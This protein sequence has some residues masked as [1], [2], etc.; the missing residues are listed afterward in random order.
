MLRLFDI[1]AEH[2]VGA[3][4]AIRYATVRRQ[5]EIGPDGLEHQT[6]SYPSVHVRLIPL[7]SRAY[8]F[9]ELG[10]ALV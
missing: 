2:G 9:I 1:Q 3:T 5:G 7:L 10:R 8:V 4:I 6:I